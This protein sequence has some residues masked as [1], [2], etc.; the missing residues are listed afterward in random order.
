MS[1]SGNETRRTIVGLEVHVQLLTNTKLFCGCSTRF[2]QPANAQVCPVCLGMPG[3]LPVLN[4]QAL[5]LG[6]LATLILEGSVSREIAFDRKQY[7]YPD[8][9]KGYQ[10]SQ[11]RFPVCRGGIVTFDVGEA[12][13]TVEL[14]E[15]RIE[16]AHLE[17]DAGKSIHGGEGIPA[18]KTAVDLNRAGTP[19]LE[20]VTRPDM[21][22]GRQ[23]RMFLSE[24]RTALM[25]MGVSDCNM[26]EGSLRCDA[27][28][29]LE[30]QSG[31]TT[32]RTPI[33]EIKNLN[34]FRAVENAVDHEAERHWQLF[35]GGDQEWLSGGK[36]TRG[37]DDEVGESFLQRE[38]EA[39]ADYRYMPEPDLPPVAIGPERIGKIRK[40][41]RPMPEMVRG[42]LRDKYG[43]AP[44]DSRV[45]AAHSAGS[46]EYF[47]IVADQCG[48]GK[49]ASNWLQQ[50]VFSWL[51]EKGKTIENYPVAAKK[52]GSLLSMI[53]RDGLNQARARDVLAEMIR[54]GSSAEAA[55]KSLGV[56]SVSEDTLRNACQKVL[57]ANPQGVQEI[58]NGKAQA[59]GPLIGQVRKSLPDANPAMI[60]EKILELLGAG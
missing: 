12:N 6:I 25:W 29:N 18:G 3:S 32:V 14:F 15:V 39:V 34:S 23:A 9:P 20:I 54:S 52:L 36:Q 38:K 53:Q 8:L 46:I 56:E 27:N 31:G 41:L 33:V 59:I 51:A 28:V 26:Q 4:S 37:W 2:G 47:Q 7:F 60:R 57:D 21:S 30:I 10:I 13:E 17:E 58:A 49:L 44:Y 19:L 40:D 42:N 50:D 5:D 1:N 16:K 43:L 35:Q 48:N 55:A 24:L 45:I 22:S 11:L